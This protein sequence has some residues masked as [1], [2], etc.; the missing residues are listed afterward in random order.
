MDWNVGNGTSSRMTVTEDKGPA[1]TRAG[2]GP[3]TYQELLE[4]YPAK[5][6]WE[7]LKTFVNSGSVF[8]FGFRYFPLTD[9][10]SDLGLLKRDRKLQLRY[11]N[12]G[13]EIKDKW[14]TMGS[15]LLA[16]ILSNTPPRSNRST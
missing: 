14:G 3:P 10:R 12:W 15:Y 6:T 7:E 11:N 9:D 16:F 2:T 8:E 5:F 1:T 4:H 13:K